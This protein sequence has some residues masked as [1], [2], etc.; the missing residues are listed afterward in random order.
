M[1]MKEIIKLSKEEKKGKT[2]FGSR[3]EHDRN[4]PLQP[5]LRLR[6]YFV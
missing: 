6:I 4:C 1:K 5:G 3:T 2:N